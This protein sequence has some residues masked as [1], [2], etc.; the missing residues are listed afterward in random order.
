MAAMRK[1]SVCEQ[2]TQEIK[3][4][5]IAAPDQTVVAGHPV[6]G[7][8][9]SGRLVVV[10]ADIMV[11]TM[12]EVFPPDHLVVVI[13]QDHLVP[14][15]VI[16]HLDRQVLGLQVHLVVA[17]VVAVVVLCTIHHLTHRTIPSCSP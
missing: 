6:C 12:V 5:Q 16:T 14:L 7:R 13:H 11:V 4:R 17:A 15:V 2:K 8:R 9:G 3:T 10:A 1:S